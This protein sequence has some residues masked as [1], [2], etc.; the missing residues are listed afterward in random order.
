MYYFEYV[1]KCDDYDDLI[2][3]DETDNPFKSLLRGKTK[4]IDE[5]ATF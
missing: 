3:H 4:K 2:P 1:R 5:F